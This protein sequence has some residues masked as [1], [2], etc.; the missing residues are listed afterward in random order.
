MCTLN[1]HKQSIKF[2]ILCSKCTIA[3][4][5]NAWCLSHTSFQT[6]CARIISLRNICIIV[7]PLYQK[8][9]IWCIRLCPNIKFLLSLSFFYWIS[10][11]CRDI[12]S[13]EVS[14]LLYLKLSR[15]Y[16]KLTKLGTTS[17]DKILWIQF[18]YKLIMDIFGKENALPSLR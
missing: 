10:G 11:I 12:S 18:L 7:I 4:Y 1:C 16:G 15:H 3:T 13:F 17:S 2:S 6:R 14:N 8:K 5:L 9:T